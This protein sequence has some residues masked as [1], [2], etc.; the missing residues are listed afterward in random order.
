M[1]LLSDTQLE[2]IHPSGDISFFPLDPGRGVLN[3]GRH[4]DNDVVLSDGSLDLFHALID[5]RQPPYQLILLVDSYPTSQTAVV[6][7]AQT[8]TMWDPFPL[9][10]YTLLLIS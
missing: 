6:G 2:V 7:T 5:V 3:I 8:L 10:N 9:G 1:T 4:P